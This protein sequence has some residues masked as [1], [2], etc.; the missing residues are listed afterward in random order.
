MVGVMMSSAC[1]LPWYYFFQDLYL[2]HLI[3]VSS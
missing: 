1:L 2:K 3:A